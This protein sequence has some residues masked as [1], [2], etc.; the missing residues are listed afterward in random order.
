MKGESKMSATDYERMG[1][2]EQQLRAIQERLA[3][4]VPID[5][6]QFAA[7]AQALAAIRPAALA[8]DPQLQGAYASLLNPIIK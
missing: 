3:S 6:K 1:G 2:I 5:T 8:A 7:L 4:G